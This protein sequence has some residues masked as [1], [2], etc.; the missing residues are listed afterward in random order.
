[1]LEAKKGTMALNLRVRAPYITVTYVTAAAT[2]NRF[3]NNMHVEVVVRWR[4]FRNVRRESVRHT[5]KCTLK[6]NGM[7]NMYL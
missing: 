6:L 7:H 1:M 2:G 5:E 4:R 3:S